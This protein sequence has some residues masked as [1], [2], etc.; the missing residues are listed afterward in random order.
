MACRCK[1]CDKCGPFLVAEV[2][3]IRGADMIDRRVSSAPGHFERRGRGCFL[4]VE[5]AHH[6]H[7][8]RQAP[9][10]RTTSRSWTASAPKRID[11]GTPVA[12]A[13]RAAPRKRPLVHCGHPVG[14]RGGG[15]DPGRSTARS[16]R[17]TT[18]PSVTSFA[19][20]S[21][22]LSAGQGVGGLLCGVRK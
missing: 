4:A 15:D 3:L 9:S 10:S 21:A 14:R 6:K 13:A 19:N 7:G 2:K 20:R 1:F 8:Q 11:S 5:S 22:N 17:G 12:S 16:R 18:M